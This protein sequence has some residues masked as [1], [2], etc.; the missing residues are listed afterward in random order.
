[1]RNND[2]IVFEDIGWDISDNWIEGKA[3]GV[4][5]ETKVIE[6]TFRGIVVAQV[7]A[8]EHES[9][10]LSI[11]ARECVSGGGH[12]ASGAVAVR[13]TGDAGYAHPEDWRASQK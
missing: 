12:Y 7:R 5:P 9:G 11:E 8:Y 3:Q 4:R 10:G 13:A 6:I 1:M 2:D